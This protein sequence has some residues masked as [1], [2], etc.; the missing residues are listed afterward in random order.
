M[1][2]LHV[3]NFLT[4]NGFYKGANDDISWHHHE[5][6]EEENNFAA[7]GANSGSALLFGRITYEMMAGYWQTKDALKNNK[8]VAEGMNKSE[9]FVF[10]KTLKKADWHNTTIINGNIISE[11]KKLKQNYNTLTILGSGSII[12]QLAE[13]ELIDEYQFMIDPMAIGEGTP[14][15]KHIKKELLFKLVKSRIFE[16]GTVLLTYA[17]R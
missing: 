6:R 17:P 10:S 1:G 13:A 11:T 15:F 14:V 4:L 8:S 2:K 3:F 7:E 9:K 12:T 5:V 16:S